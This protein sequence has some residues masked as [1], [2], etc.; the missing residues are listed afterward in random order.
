MEQMRTRVRSFIVDTFLFGDG[1]DLEDATSFLELGIVYSMGILELINFLE[2]DFG[3][4]IHEED[5]VPENFDSI[6]QVLAFVA[7][8]GGAYK[9]KSAAG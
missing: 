8:K 2:S 6:D 1:S 4:V 9:T 5:L 3:L 7:R